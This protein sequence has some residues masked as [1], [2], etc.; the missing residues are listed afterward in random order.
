MY[1]PKRNL[2]FYLVEY[3]R[4][5]E[6]LLDYYIDNKNLDGIK[7]LLKDPS[8]SKETL[9]RAKKVLKDLKA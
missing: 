8:C 6:E 4:Q 9:N 7:E 1:L 2:L 3:L 5:T